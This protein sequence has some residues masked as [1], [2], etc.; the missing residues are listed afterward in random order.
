MRVNDIGYVGKMYRPIPARSGP[1][2][3]VGLESKLDVGSSVGSGDLPELRAG[4]ASEV[5]INKNL[6]ATESFYGQ[7]DDVFGFLAGA[8]SGQAYSSENDIYNYAKDASV[9]SKILANAFVQELFPTIVKY[10]GW[11]RSGSD[12]ISTLFGP[13]DD[14]GLLDLLNTIVTVNNNLADFQSSLKNGRISE[15]DYYS[16]FSRNDAKLKDL[17]SKILD[18]YKTQ[19]GKNELSNDDKAYAIMSWVQ[20]HLEYVS[21][22]KHHG[23]DEKWSSAIETLRD[24]LA[25]CEDGGFLEGGLALA[26]GI[27]SSRIRFYGGLVRAGA[28]AETG[29]HGWWAYKRETDDEWVVLDWCYLPSKEAIADRTRMKD[30]RN[31]ISDWFVIMGNGLTI[32]TGAINSVRNPEALDKWNDYRTGY[33]GKTLAL[34]DFKTSGKELLAAQKYIGNRMLEA[35][36][37][38][39]GV[40]QGGGNVLLFLSEFQKRLQEGNVLEMQKNLS[41]AFGKIVGSDDYAEAGAKAS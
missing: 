37:E 20:D 5:Q 14:G 41:E 32:D 17:S 39:P 13:K 4:Y 10:N 26:S 8:I 33:T 31:Y 22:L 19:I 15:N 9:K 36:F 29:G 7:V 21:D 34:G 16:Y 24:L 11:G 25:D 6:I 3:R 18:D 12:L 38:I 27:D 1:I 40:L 35:G 30:D 2:E 23:V 28:N